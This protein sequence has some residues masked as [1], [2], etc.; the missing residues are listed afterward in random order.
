MTSFTFSAEQVRSAPPAVRQWIENEIAATLRALMGGHQ[1]SPSGHSAEL[2]ACTAEEA[3]QIYEL[4]REDLATTLV[5]L[6]LA[7]EPI[8][9]ISPSLNAL[10]IGDI[11]RLTR[12]NDSRLAECFRTI[13]QIFQQL[14]SDPEAMLFAFDQASHVYIHETTHRSIRSLWERLM[15]AP[16]MATMPPAASPPLGFTPPQVG[17]SEDVATHNRS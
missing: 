15:R 9:N 5:F 4:I 10:N 8:G 14:R 3:L 17:P 12:L 2:A 1:E 16:A 11:I 13:N 6:E 7:H